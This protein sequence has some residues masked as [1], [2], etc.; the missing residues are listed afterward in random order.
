MTQPKIYI[1]NPIILDVEQAGVKLV[2]DTEIFVEHP[3][4]EGYYISSCG[5]LFS[6][7]RKRL[8]IEQSVGSNQKRPA[9]RLPDKGSYKCF[10]VGKLV[11]DIFVFNPYADSVKII[12]HHKDEN[13]YNNHYSNLEYLTQKE[14]MSLHNGRRIY[15]YD[16]D[17]EDIVEFLS[18]S[19]LARY[20]NIDINIINRA[21]Y[22]DSYI[23]YDDTRHNY[24]VQLKGVIYNGRPLYI[25]YEKSIPTESK[26]NGSR[27]GAVV[28]LAG[29]AYLLYK[30]AKK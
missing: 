9:F 23:H 14:H 26:S 30:A 8:L 24:V 4:F 25:G 5:R 13:P 21:I 10:K 2:D 20:F 12:I 19:E 18:V 27:L 28:I 16:T 7:K 6:V 11:S 17:T 3:N 15:W 1:D 29:L 22:N